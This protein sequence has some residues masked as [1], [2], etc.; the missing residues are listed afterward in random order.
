MGDEST[1][2]GQTG[3][4]TDES[5][6]QGGPR[7]AGWYR[8]PAPANP[9]FPTTVR[10]WDGKEWTGQ[11]K[12][13]TKRQRQS[14]QAELA[15]EAQARAEEQY[16]RLQA[17]TTPEHIAAMTQANQRYLTVDGQELSGWWRRVFARVIDG[18][19]LN[20]V[21]LLFGWPFIREVGRAMQTYGDQLVLA[22]QVGAPLPDPTAFYS[23]VLVATLKLTVV[24]L[25]LSALYE[26]GFVKAFG[27]TPGKM[28]LGIEIRLC[29][30]PGPMSW[31]TVLLRWFASLVC[32]LIPFYL[33]ALWPLWDSRRQAI[34]D[35]IAS[36]QV[37][38]R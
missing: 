27:A 13:A 1:Q 24:S 7:P 25:L 19:I 12:H 6:G 28:A 22:Q 32:A 20:V 15:A 29:E 8:D 36:T 34:H 37:C 4:L 17:S 21:L 9:D 2:T 5:T 16:R 3:Q 38:R 30:R 31:G 14:W 26:C 18:V 11:T 33:D 10:F 23:A 35:H